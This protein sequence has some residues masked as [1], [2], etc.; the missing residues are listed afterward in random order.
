[1]GAGAH[2]RTRTSRTGAHGGRR[3][4]LAMG[5]VAL[6]IA[7][8]VA[9]VQSGAS[10][11]DGPDTPAPTV[12]GV[13][14]GS[15]PAVS[16]ASVTIT[17]TNFSG[18][19]DGTNFTATAVSF[20]STAA[21][22]FVVNS[23]TTITA[24]EPG[25]TGTVDVTVTTA[26][27]TSATSSA[28]QYSY[29]ADWSQGTVTSL[30]STASA[31]SGV[32]GPSSQ[33][34]YASGTGPYANFQVSVNQTQNLTD[35]AV[36]VSWTGAP[37]TLSDTSGDFLGNYVQVFECWSNPSTGESP[38]PSQCEF[39]GESVNP[40]SYPI[41]LADQGESHVFSR[42]LAQPGWS[43]DDTPPS[44][45]VSVGTE[46]CTDTSG[47][48]PTD[49]VIQPFE[50]A[51]GTVVK[52]QANYNYDQDPFAPEPF[53]LNPYFSYTTT[54]EA[55]FGRT[56]DNGSGQVL[57][58]VDTGLNA[59]GL[60]CGQTIQQAVGTGSVT[61]KCWLV[62]VPRGDLGQENPA[63]LTGVGSVVT[64]PLTSQAW[65]DRITIPLGFNPVGTK[66]S[67]NA[68]SQGI[69]GSELAVDAVSSWE[70]AL[71]GL[72][73]AQSFS[74]LQDNDDTARQNLTDPT[75]GSVGMSVFSDPIPT[76]ETKANNPVVYAP[77]TLSG[78]VIA[79]NI[80]RVAS[81]LPNGTRQSNELA[82]ADSRVQNLYLTPL[83]VAKLLTQ[84]YQAELRGVTHATPANYEWAVNNPVS[85]FT[86]PG[87]LQYNPEFALMTTSEQND[88]ADMVVEEGS[89]DA[90]S[91]LWKW[92]LADPAARAWLDGT[93]TPDGKPE[94]MQVNPYYSINPSINPSHVAFGTPTPETYPKNDPWCDPLTDLPLNTPP[95]PAKSVSRLICIQDWSPY[96][97]SMAAAAEAAA[98][99]N[100]GG[101]TT[102]NPTGTTD[103]AWGAN[104]PQTTGDDF[105]I[106]VTDS[107][108]AARY[109]LQ[110]ASLSAAG[111]DTNPTFVAPTSASILAG[112]QAMKPSGVTGVLQ[113]DP[114]TTNT[115]AYPLSMLTYAAATPETLNASSRQNYAAFLQYA[116]GSTA[117]TTGVAPGELPAGYVPL[118]AALVAQTVA[119]AAE[120]L[121]PP[122]ESNPPSTALPTSASSS[123]T[124]SSGSTSTNSESPGSVSSASSTPGVSSSRSHHVVHRT[125]GQSALSAVQIGGLSV[126]ALRWVLPIVLLIGLA[127]ALGFVL[128]K[129][130][131]RK[132]AT[133]GA[134]A[135]S[136]EPESEP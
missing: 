84:S 14:P 83:L 60:G 114:S 16:G 54:N 64:S 57:F 106:S 69:I 45:T 42:V 33:P 91:L 79:F 105:I 108:S 50:A 28:D 93:P 72:P 19:A 34:L 97:L 51:D 27:G 130:T 71:C 95:N 44:C 134:P 40:S 68:T 76:S 128:M 3:P 17:G 15:G 124:S 125:I 80:Q 120:I 24:T 30:P 110:T 122:A 94:G 104:G 88:A 53:W 101:K 49:F 109:G 62:V 36:S 78:A 75:Y 129:I 82:L 70:P 136:D 73:G 98:T 31:V 29:V 135:A 26:G 13:S 117:Q 126:G 7:G 21:A 87:F 59:P 55:D 8:I 74:Y 119:T 5:V 66:C 113:T 99:A 86:D 38:S 102:F 123:P 92:V 18:T 61:P 133:V 41:D 58:D 121:H 96:V 118:P 81:V 90:A 100:D 43:T 20:G 48:S 11:T 47:T 112:E 111:D 103:T 22:S 56:L 4:W 6:A 52:Q 107:A 63:G 67:I 46:P 132:A 10:A 12:T 23:A 116:S 39:G 32:T 37:P 65:A 2:S 127:A 77:L 89:S 85:I 25:G 9:G 1:M 115:N 131:G 35:Q